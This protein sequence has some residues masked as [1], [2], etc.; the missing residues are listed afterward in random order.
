M[1][2]SE[3]FSLLSLKA[4]TGIVKESQNDGNM[5]INYLV[6]SPTWRHLWFI[7]QTTSCEDRRLFNYDYFL[8]QENFEDGKL[9]F[10]GIT[11]ISDL[12][13]SRTGYAKLISLIEKNV[14]RSEMAIF[15]KEWYPFGTQTWQLTR[16]KCNGANNATLKFNNVSHLHCFSEHWH[17]IINR[18]HE[19]AAK[20]EQNFSDVIIFQ[21]YLK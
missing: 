21:I 8:M 10:N 4:L 13:F 6:P 18:H 17:K 19:N 15:S 3:L 20:D 1:L 16:S 2:S 14:S 11:K 9:I 12:D 5:I 7:P